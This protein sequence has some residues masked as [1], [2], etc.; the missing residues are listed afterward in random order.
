MFR[1]LK[2]AVIAGSA[3]ML[4]S[5]FAHADYVPVGTLALYGGFAPIVNNTAVATTNGS[6]TIS[7]YSILLSSGTPN[8]RSKFTF[9][10]GTGLFLTSDSTIYG[11]DL[12]GITSGALISFNPTVGNVVQ[13]S[14]NP[15]NNLFSFT[16]TTTGET[17]DFDLDQSITTLNDSTTGTGTSVSLYLLGDLTATG[18]T[19]YSTDT[20]T[21]ITL[22]LTTTGGS[23]WS[24]SGTLS[25]PP[26]GLPV[27]EPASMLVLGSGLAALGFIRRRRQRG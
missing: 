8:F 26:P 3:L 5:G 9:G 15:L 14:V 7:P 27:P 16:D 4:G 10:S 12:P 24:L 23:N 25:N 6:A 20:P 19:N 13:Y 21:A 22:S 18:T 11:N 17:Y 2:L 1:A